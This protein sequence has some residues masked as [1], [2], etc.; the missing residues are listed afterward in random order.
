MLTGATLEELLNQLRVSLKKPTRTPMWLERQDRLVEAVQAVLEAAD[1]YIPGTIVRSLG[2][3]S[4]L[5]DAVHATLGA[6]RGHLIHTLG[7]AKIA[8]VQ[9]LLAGD[10]PNFMEILNVVY[11][12]NRHSDALRWLLDP[13]CA[14]TIAGPA[15]LSLATR[16]DQPETWA[17]EI[18]RAIDTTAL[19]VQREYT[20]AYQWAEES[21]LDR[22]DLVVSSPSFLLAIENKVKA[23]E[24]AE[25]TQRYWDWLGSLQPPQFLRAGIFLSPSGISPICDDFKPI[26]YLD[27]LSCLLEGSLRA[28]LGTEEQLVLSAYIKTLATGILRSELRAI[29]A[30]GLETT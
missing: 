5:V 11:E 2:L 22:I 29:S 14:P 4:G 15:L 1:R 6:W 27:L 25:Q 9:N 16:L 30:G 7:Q 26:S 23:K 20:P 17:I 10:A 8:A 24:H 18:E 12:E 28:T 3:R 13:R 19:S 21:C